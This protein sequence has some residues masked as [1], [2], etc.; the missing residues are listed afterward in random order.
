MVYRFKD[1]KKCRCHYEDDGTPHP[2][3][4]YYPELI[5]IGTD[6]DY[7]EYSACHELAHALGTGLK[8][9]FS[10]ERNVE[11]FRRELFTWRLA[12]SY[13]KPKYINDERAIR[14]LKTYAGGLDY[15]I[16]WDRL[17][18]IP[19]NTNQHLHRRLREIK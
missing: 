9:H 11:L 18:I 19:V 6:S 3:G 10:V 5:E 17:R 14:C 16:N 8:K 4:G 1:N 15:N 7:W 12:K 13:C 2:I